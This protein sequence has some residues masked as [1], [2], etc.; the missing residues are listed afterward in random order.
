[1]IKS[2]MIS[3]WERRCRILVRNPN[4]NGLL[5]RSKGKYEDNTKR[6]LKDIGWGAVDCIHLA[7][8]KDQ[9][10]GLIN[11]VMNLRVS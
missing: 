3:A 8:D 10:R 1:M 9:W 7:H 2:R 11:T 5:G 6:D 4:G